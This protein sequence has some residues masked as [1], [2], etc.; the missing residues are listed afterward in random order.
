MNSR[1]FF[2]SFLFLLSSCSKEPQYDPWVIKKNHH[3]QGTA[4][5]KIHTSRLPHRGFDVVWQQNGEDEWILLET[6]SLVFEETNS[7]E[8]IITSSNSRRHFKSTVRKGG[9]IVQLPPEAIS[10]LHL[11]QKE[12]QPFL[13]QAG[14]LAEELSWNEHLD[15]IFHSSFLKPLF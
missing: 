5:T 4:Y 14:P 12:N 11:L 15:A 1:L 2:L 10:F 3:D 13:I 6:S 7:I 9:Q 8:V